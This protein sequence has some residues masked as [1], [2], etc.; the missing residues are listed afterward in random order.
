MFYEKKAAYWTLVRTVITAQVL[1][2]QH[3]KTEGAV[4]V[5]CSEYDSAV[6]MKTSRRTVTLYS[7]MPGGMCIRLPMCGFTCIEVAISVESPV[8]FSSSTRMTTIRRLL[9]L[10]ICSVY[11]SAVAGG[12]PVSVD[13]SLLFTRPLSSSHLIS[14]ISIVMFS[15]MYILGCL[16]SLA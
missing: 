1:I 7:H 6:Q 3:R 4:P 8:Q 13:T 5:Q 12:T 15:Y 11:L 16:C 9:F 14:H 2:G 10:I